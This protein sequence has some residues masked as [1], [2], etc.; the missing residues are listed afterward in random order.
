[1]TTH[2][3]TV[4]FYDS[5]FIYDCPWSLSDYLDTDSFFPSDDVSVSQRHDPAMTHA[6]NFTSVP[7]RSL[8][9]VSDVSF[10]DQ[11][12]LLAEQKQ[13]VTPEFCSASDCTTRDST[14]VVPFLPTF[15][16]PSSTDQKTAAKNLLEK[17]ENTR[18][19]KGAKK[20][21]I[22]TGANQLDLPVGLQDLSPTGKTIRST[23]L[24]DSGCTSSIIDE[25][26]V[27]KH[28]LPT[29]PLDKPIPA[30]NADGTKNAAGS[31]T[32]VTELR[33]SIGDHTEKIMFAI[34]R[35]DGHD[36]YLGFSWLNLHNPEIDWT[37]RTI[38][39]TRCPRSCNYHT[40]TINPEDDED[41]LE[42]EK[43]RREQ[44]ESREE[45]PEKESDELKAGDRLFLFNNESYTRSV[46]QQD[47]DIESRTSFAKELAASLPKEIRD[48]WAVFGE[49]GYNERL[50]ER[51]PWDHT[52]E[53]TPG[54][55]PTK[56]KLYPVPKSQQQELNDFL[57]ENLR[58]GQIRESKSPMS[59]PFFFIKKADGSL[60]PVQ[61]YRKLNEMTIK[62]RYPLPLIGELLDKLQDAEFFSK[63]DIRWGFTN[64]RIK[65]GDEW[66]AAFLT[67]RGLF[68]P[69]VMFFGMCNAPA[70]FQKMMNDI[71][72]ELIE[73]GKIIVYMDDILIFTKTE[74]E[75]WE[76]VREVLSLL[77]KHKLSLKVAKCEFCKPEIPFLGMIIGHQEIRM[78]PK[79]TEAISEWPILK[80]KKEVQQFL[81]FCNFYRRFIKDFSKIARPLTQLTG[82]VEFS[83]GTEEQ[84]AFDVLKNALC[85]SPI[86]SVYRNNL[87]LR[88][89][90]D[91]SDFALG[92]VLSQHQD[93]KWH[94]LAY[95]S[96]SLN[97]TERNYEIYDKELMAIVS[98]L[99]EWR[100]YL[101]DTETPFEIWS[102]HQNL[103]YF[104]EPQKLNRRQA[105]WFQELQDYNYSLHHKPGSL[106]GKPDAITRRP[107]LNKGETDN[108]NVTMLKPEHF[109]RLAH[110]AS[111]VQTQS[112]TSIYERI[113]KSARQRD[114]IVVKELAS[115]NK[116]WVERDDGVVEWKS[117]IY[118]PK[119]RLLRQ[120]LLMMYHDAPLAGH[121]GQHKTLEL[122][123]RD[124]WWPGIS[125]DVKKYVNG[126]ALC[127]QNKPLHRPG[128]VPLSPHDVPSAPWESVSMDLIGPLPESKG[129]DAIL[130]VVCLYSKRIHTMP[131][132]TT[133]TALGVA[134]LLRDNIFKHH[135]LPRKFISDRGPQ[136]IAEVMTE[137]YKLLGI[138]YNPS[139]AAHPETDGQT[140]RA[141]QEIEA[142]LRIYS[143]YRQDDWVDWLAIQEFC[144]NNRVSSAT[145]YSPFFLETGRNPNMH[146]N[147][148][149]Q[150]RNVD[151]QKFFD[152]MKRAHEDAEAA[153]RKAKDDM[154]R[155]YDRNAREDPG[156]S[157]GDKV[158]LETT[159]LKVERPSR[160][161][162]EKRLGPFEV[163]EK[164][165]Q[166]S[167]KLKLPKTWQVKTPVFHASLL[168]KYTP[169]N[170]AVQKAPEPPPTEVR[171]NVEEYVVE[172]IVDSRHHRGKLQYRVHWAGYPLKKDYTWEPV[173]NI[174]H[175][176]EAVK[177][178]HTKNPSAPRPIDTRQIKFRPT[179][180]DLE[181][182]EQS[183]EW[184]TGISEHS[185]WR[186]GRP[187]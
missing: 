60:R 122:I 174:T 106:M 139:S 41:E 90:C 75:H 179:Y 87:P 56:A 132:R 57:E 44:E 165:G 38:H 15:E 14:P 89:E 105:R 127:Q 32:R 103:G 18:R 160:K 26:F 140:E 92:A 31:I 86:L 36:L 136:F 172:E 138:E 20:I 74:A 82:N 47:E 163:L 119:H 158:W 34:V 65:E 169:P 144:Y 91:A 161:L 117:R 186:S 88:V 9:P 131:C 121:P 134:E 73:K 35:L 45:L 146:Y 78:D 40:R 164:I 63:V 94:P 83:W 162:S 166:T 43:D 21:V 97:E 30:I 187:P 147:P 17:S 156:Y 142:F 13:D 102:D 95:Y 22:G 135:G 148:S 176:D 171:D 116:D 62:N 49:P 167:Y 100:Q 170:F 69:L 52:I 168:H 5:P 130:V 84:Q 152:E 157:V 151:A 79:K 126:C 125:R 51:R 141:N 185:R 2:K 118:V 113:R 25:E 19:W 67:N 59:S 3:K 66:K 48:Y 46:K 99:E 177:D 143:N 183:G 76:V 145:G 50:P 54:F 182:V 175:A 37:H 107:D 115:K 180:I 16:L 61:D 64:V 28:K 10:D 70:T 149:R 178:F 181:E 124:Y 33:V 96:R 109:R 110:R 81:G 4:Q 128:K 104:R 155:W 12:A 53:L 24:L 68:E 72:K 114:E 6:S 77:A 123:T 39:F 93:E 7:T 8:S 120:D 11:L 111:E 112:F 129:M 150:S 58:N 137:L 98:S 184:M 154:K 1:M 55:S 23:A 153:M 27:R 71:F 108:K 29:W 133:I 85:S 42:R 101:L 80:S 173:E 159:N